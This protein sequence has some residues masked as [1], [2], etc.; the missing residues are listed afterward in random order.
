MVGRHLLIGI[1]ENTVTPD[2]L[3][4]LKQ[5]QP[6]GLILFRRNFTTPQALRD[7]LTALDREL[8][9]RLLIAV[10]HEG[11]R[12]I[13]L[14]GGIS[15]FPDNLVLGQ[16]GSDAWAIEQGRI[17]AHELRR[18]GIDLNLAPTLDVLTDAFSPNIGIRSYGKDVQ[19]VIHLGVARIRGMQANG[20]SACAKHF[21]GQGHSPEDAHLSLPVLKSDWAEMRGKHLLPFQAAIAAG[22]HA[23]MSSHPIYPELSAKRVYEPAT[24]STELITDLLRTEMKFDGLVLTDDLE[25][26]ALTGFAD[27]GEVVTRSAAAGHDLLLICRSRE[28]QVLAWESLRKAYEKG[29][30]KKKA[31]EDT[32]RRLDKLQAVRKS[33][34]E[35]GDLLPEPSS[36]SL[37]RGICERGLSVRAS[38]SWKK[39]GTENTLV[40]F[41]RLSSLRSLYYMEPAQL[42]EEKYVRAVFLE[43]GLAVSGVEVVDFE[44]NESRKDQI[45]EKASAADRVIFFCYDAHLYPGTK[46]LLL[47]LQEVAAPKA[48][49]FLRDP[50]DR[51]WLKPETAEVQVCGFRDQQIRT[52]VRKLINSVS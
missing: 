50:Y 51:E 48:V 14:P 28:K 22:V 52:A 37:I 9:R 34:F 26:G 17:E 25:M 4:H 1:E 36:A 46:D 13:H 44:P 43:N 40:I 6:A 23:I 32:I 27:F 31:L 39:H 42:D 41:P 21:P 30:L 29:K 38:Q 12:V 49:F 10:D 15:V 35:A 24:F 5:I 18:L 2:L 11:G 33:R 16:G 3:K 7:F 8:G 47:R 20:L 19:Q 45:V